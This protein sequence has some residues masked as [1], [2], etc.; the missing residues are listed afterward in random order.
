[1]RPARGFTLIE[2]LVASVIL[3]IL[4]VMAHRGVAETRLAV[5]R[6]REHMTRVR[7]VQRAVTLMTADFRQLAPRPVRELVG[8]GYRPALL[9]DPNAVD[10]VELSRQGWPNTA[11]TPRGTV[12][13]VVYLLEGRT[14]VRR[15]WNVT[16]ATLS[17]EPVNRDLLGEVDSVTIRY[18]N[19]GREWQTQWPALGAAPEVALRTRPLAVEIVIELSDYGEIRRV[20]EVPG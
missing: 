18:M 11:G 8:D 1:M 9:R 12:Q 13:R 6:V 16:D 10:L 17:N 2:V 7:E 20:V 3:A 19:A 5:D 15:H 14:L 4:A